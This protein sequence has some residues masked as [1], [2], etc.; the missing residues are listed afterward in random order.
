M[1]RNSSI[2][3]SSW[4][5]NKLKIRRTSQQVTEEQQ[6]SAETATEKDP[7]ENAGEEHTAQAA[8]AGPGEQERDQAM[9][10]WLRRVPDDPSGLLREKF[11]YESLKRQ[12]QGAREDD[13]VYW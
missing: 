11:R 9:E 3:N 7:Q 12:E 6:D 8:Q 2:R 1:N 5:R 4:R 10:Q 13:E